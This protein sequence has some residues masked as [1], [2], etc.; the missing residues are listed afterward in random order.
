METVE[1]IMIRE[2]Y[3]IDFSKPLQE[4]KQLFDKYHIRHLPVISKGKLIGMLS[5][6][7]I[8]RLSFGDTYC[9]DKSEMDAALWSMQSIVNV[10]SHH[11]KSISAIDFI[12]KVASFFNQNVAFTT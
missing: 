8:M 11:P 7:D 3:K 6:T 5:R 9:T 1:Q 10:S 12:D 2:V 4:A